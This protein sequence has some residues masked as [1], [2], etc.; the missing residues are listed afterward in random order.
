[1]E[2][3]PDRVH[4]L[5]SESER[6]KQYL[7]ALPLEALSKPSACTQWQVQ[8]VIAHLIGVA[9]TYANSV[10][11]GLQGDTG[12]LPGRLPAGQATAALSAESI[13]Q[14][15]IAA[16][17]TLGDQLLA[18]F[19][20]ANDRLNNLLAGLELEQRDMPCYHP[21]GIVKARNFMDLR[22]K[23]LAMHE[24]DIRSALEPEA[25]VSPASLPAI[26]TTISES[27]ASGSLRWAF[28]SGPYLTTPV[29]YH[30]VVTG[31][32]PSKPD[33]VVEGNT[34]RME[35]A[36]ETPARVTMRCDTETYILLVYGR[37]DLEA[38]LASGRLMREGDHE[39]ARAFGRWFRGI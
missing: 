7:H 29:R 11:R 25:H 28:W 18:I 22:L 16:R 2:T 14:R 13:A 12:P 21:G 34:L 37:L 38:V 24:W 19:D 3:F 33:I 8:D 6:I 15:S 30:F 17:K 39:L 31:L 32:G 4:V 20:A 23:E 36:G 26:M 10:S 9:E 35:D 27:I 5:Q 1:M